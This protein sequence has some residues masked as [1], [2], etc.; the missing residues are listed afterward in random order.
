MFT[1]LAVKVSICVVRVAS[2]AVFINGRRA[3]AAGR[4]P[5]QRHKDDEP[6]YLSHLASPKNDGPPDGG[7]AQVFAR[8]EKKVMGVVRPPAME[9]RHG[10]SSA[11]HGDA[12]VGNDGYADWASL[13]SQQRR[14]FVEVTNNHQE[15]RATPFVPPLALGTAKQ[16]EVSAK[17]R[18]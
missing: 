15:N 8:P 2:D 16:R 12:K 3:A 18:S 7:V 17:H 10:N 4:R 1:R 6:T 11:L 13:E 14:G 5:K 9:P